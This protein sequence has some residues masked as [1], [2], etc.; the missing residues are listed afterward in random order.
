M[1]NIVWLNMKVH[2]LLTK[3][4]NLLHCWMVFLGKLLYF[5][6]IV[7]FSLFL[8]AIALNRFLEMRVNYA[9]VSVCPE[10]A[11]QEWCTRL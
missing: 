6:C 4:A 3:R 5:V 2:L 8:V 1:D 10:H 7:K 9:Q 11:P